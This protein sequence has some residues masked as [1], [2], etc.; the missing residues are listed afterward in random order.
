MQ[1]A[2]NPRKEDI[3]NVEHTVS[4][5]EFAFRLLENQLI[6]TETYQLMLTINNASIE[7][8]LY[9]NPELM[10]NIDKIDDPRIRAGIHTLLQRI[11]DGDK[12]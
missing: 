6:G 1:E 4:V 10:A 3:V 12:E 8:E 9:E 11:I 5:G 7:G 2:N